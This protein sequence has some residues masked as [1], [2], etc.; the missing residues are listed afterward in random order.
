MRSVG[1]NT[2]N[3]VN[4][5]AGVITRQFVWLI[6]K[7]RGTGADET[8]GFWNG[9]YDIS[10]NV[11][12]GQTGNPEIRTYVGAGSL[13]EIDDIALVSDLTIQ[14]LRVKLTQTNA[15]VN[16][17][18]RGYDSRNAKIEVHYGLFDKATRLLVDLPYP[19]FVG[20][21]NKAPI[22]RA[23]VG[24]SGGVIAECVSRV[25]ELTRINPAKKSDETQKLRS[26]DRFRRYSGVADQWAIWWG[27]EKSND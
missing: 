18:I 3:Y 26:G 24:T 27:E 15:A 19:H 6:A 22:T 7:N 8:V 23:K 11:I 21:V 1:A 14:T 17:A 20:E 4:G 13:L 10:V 5:R 16:N 12:S 25:R 9:P 2:V